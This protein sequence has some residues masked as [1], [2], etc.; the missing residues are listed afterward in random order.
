ML[1]VHMLDEY[2]DQQ[3]GEATPARMGF[4]GGRGGGNGGRDK[5]KPKRGGPRHFTVHPRDLYDTKPREENEESSEEEVES[6]EEEVCQK[7]NVLQI[8]CT[9]D[10]NDDSEDES[11][12]DEEEDEKLQQKAPKKPIPSA[13]PNHKPALKE[14]SNHDAP[15]AAK[16]AAPKQPHEMSRRE[17][18]A[19]EKERARQHFLKM[20]EKEDAARLA[21]IKKQREEAAAAAAAAK[22]AKEEASMRRR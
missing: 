7:M 4:R 2:L 10:K 12:E 9:E 16:P 1:V 19:I 11:S 21:I 5:V 6:G 13:N 18:E 8:G 3:C 17:R 14:A 22:K 15:A 20:K